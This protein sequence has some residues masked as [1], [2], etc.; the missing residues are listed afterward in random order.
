[1]AHEKRVEAPEQ[2]LFTVTWH[3]CV[4]ARTEAEARA[5]A[6]RKFK[7]D[8]CQVTKAR[9]MAQPPNEETHCRHG[10]EWGSYCDY[11]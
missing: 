2:H 3:E 6:T 1:V 7:K 4:W 9:R 5:K 8:R 11:C 10:R